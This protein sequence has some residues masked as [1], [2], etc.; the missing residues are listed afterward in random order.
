MVPVRALIAS[1][2]GEEMVSV[3]K[4][5]DEKTTAITVNGSGIIFNSITHQN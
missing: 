2:F 4:W 3:S 1:A 5:H